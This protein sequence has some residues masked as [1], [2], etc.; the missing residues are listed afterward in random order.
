[1]GTILKH[2]YMSP[3]RSCLRI[4][5]MNIFIFCDFAWFAVIILWLLSEDGAV[6]GGVF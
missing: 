2:T 5:P 6:F 3:K 4:Q 1:M